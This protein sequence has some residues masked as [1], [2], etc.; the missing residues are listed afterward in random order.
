M[1]AFGSIWEGTA[2]LALP[3]KEEGI[4]KE[5]TYFLI[6][7]SK[8]VLRSGLE[9]PPSPADGE[10]EM[11]VDGRCCSQAWSFG[12]AWGDQEPSPT[13]EGGGR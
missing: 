2:S 5:E 11:D 9:M 3:G 4:T 8:L 10:R 6:L 1:K 12:R 7:N 13:S